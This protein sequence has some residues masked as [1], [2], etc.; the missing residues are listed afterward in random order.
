M[1]IGTISVKKLDRVFPL[2][3]L[4]IT[5]DLPF[6]MTIDTPSGVK[7]TISSPSKVYR[8]FPVADFQRRI[9]EDLDASIS[10]SG[11]KNNS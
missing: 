11:E 8:F 6:L 9:S 4:L 2:S 1:K 10:P 7:P 5:I 3:M